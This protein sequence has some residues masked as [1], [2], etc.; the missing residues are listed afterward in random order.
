MVRNRRQ[1][2]ISCLCVTRNRPA[3]LQQAIDCFVE[4]T[5]QRKELIIVF[6]DDDLLTKEVGVENRIEDIH[7][8]EV[9][10]TPRLSLGS[11]RNISIAK[12]NGEYFCQW[13]DDDWY[14]NLRLE[15]Q[16]DSI[17]SS[18]KPA[19]L[20]AY[21]LMYDKINQR[22]FLSLG[23]WPGTVLCRK[24]I[25]DNNVKYPDLTRYEDTYFYKKLIQNNHIFPLAIPSLYIYTYNG[26]NTF[27][28]DH[29]E[30]L[31]S[32]SQQ[33][34]KRITNLF[35]RIFEKR[36]SGARASKILLSRSFL[37]ELNYFYNFLRM[38]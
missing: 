29:F 21:W 5:Y 18:H 30:R 6:E 26:S 7:F 11:L 24:S 16:M 23:P 15:L 33:L 2:L 1:P 14:H 12:A 37:K 36:I 9:V 19:C 20:L 25:I 35:Q 17:L 22:S 10:S 4:Q 8:I 32:N 31:F 34:P 13:D 38:E 27:D 28:A 3:Q